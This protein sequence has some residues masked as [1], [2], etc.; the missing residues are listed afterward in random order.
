LP[1]TSDT[2]SDE[3][4]E[5]DEPDEPEER[6][7]ESP[8]PP[9]PPPPP[10]SPDQEVSRAGTWRRVRVRDRVRVGARVGVMWVG[11]IRLGLGL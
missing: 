5:P 3:S 2:V 8:T 10:G 9:P 7:I 11:A 6:P 1:E 4:D